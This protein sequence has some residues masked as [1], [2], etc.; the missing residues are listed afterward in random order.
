MK[1]ENFDQYEKAKKYFE[2]SPVENAKLNEVNERVEPYGKAAWV[3][4]L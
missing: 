4:R 3:R 1:R 2:R